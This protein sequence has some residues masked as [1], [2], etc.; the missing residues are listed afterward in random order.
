MVSVISFQLLLEILQETW[1]GPRSHDS[2][3]SWKGAAHSIAGIS[4]FNAQ[5]LIDICTGQVFHLSWCV[6]CAF[7]CHGLVVRE[8]CRGFKVREGSSER[9]V[10]SEVEKCERGG[11]KGT[12]RTA[13]LFSQIGDG[14]H[15]RIWRTLVGESKPLGY[16]VSGQKT[17][18]SHYY[19]NKVF[20]IF[21]GCPPS[22]SCA[23][24]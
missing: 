13:Q 3:A 9:P 16:Q 18:L 23:S 8:A 2:E 4:F 6:R 12:H 15:H 17:G 24:E 11:G 1:A 7:C 21:Q 19:A 20:C 10:P 14:N 22:R 5:L